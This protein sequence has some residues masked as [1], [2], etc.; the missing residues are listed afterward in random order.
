MAQTIDLSKVPGEV[1]ITNSGTKRTKINCSGY[2]QSI[3]VEAGDSV[4]FRVDT[5]SELI[6]LL[7]QET[8]AVSVTVPLLRIGEAA[9]ETVEEGSGT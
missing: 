7:S 9:E 1:T 4:I 2:S 3:P 6:G 8:D 5:T